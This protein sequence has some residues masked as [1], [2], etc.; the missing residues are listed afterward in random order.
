VNKARVLTHD[1][2]VSRLPT[3][4]KLYRDG[5]AAG[6]AVSG[7]GGRSDGFDGFDVLGACVLLWP[8]TGATLA[9]PHLFQKTRERM[10]RQLHGLK[11]KG[12]VF[13]KRW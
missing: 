1:F 4:W 13:I 3:S 6:G 5:R 7:G 12:G 8:R 2:A 9:G 10:T 11:E